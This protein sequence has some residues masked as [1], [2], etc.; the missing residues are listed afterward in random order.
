MKRSKVREE[1]YLDPG[2]GM[3]V[4]NALLSL[5]PIS[6]VFITFSAKILLNMDKRQVALVQFKL[7]T[8]VGNT[9]TF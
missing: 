3:G 9:R 7:S 5:G 1:T 6:F 4:R 2:H 8:F